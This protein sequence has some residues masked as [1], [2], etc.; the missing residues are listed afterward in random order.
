MTTTMTT[1]TRSRPLA[2]SLLRLFALLFGLALAGCTSI[3]LIT[4][5]TSGS[6]R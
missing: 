3:T 4:G 5:G 1:L 6:R 2:P